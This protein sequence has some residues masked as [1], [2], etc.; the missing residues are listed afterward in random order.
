L[1]AG[2]GK[3]IEGMDEVYK[4]VNSPVKYKTDDLYALYPKL[5]DE[6][7]EFTEAEIEL[8]KAYQAG[9]AFDRPLDPPVIESMTVETFGVS[10]A[11]PNKLK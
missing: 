5:G 9:E 4:I 8:I 3:V 1:Y 11:E 10:Y 2:F 6:E 7:A